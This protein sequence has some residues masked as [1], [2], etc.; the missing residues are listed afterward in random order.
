[1]FFV[2]LE[3]RSRAADVCH[4]YDQVLAVCGVRRGGDAR[5]RRTPSADRL[6]VRWIDRGHLPTQRTTTTDA[7]RYE[8]DRVT[9]RSCLFVRPYEISASIDR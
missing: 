5:S 2:E 4:S 9:T 1:M 7:L 6:V 8:H 3:V